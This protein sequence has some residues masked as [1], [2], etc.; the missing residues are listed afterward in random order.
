KTANQSNI[1]LEND[2]SVSL[3]KNTETKLLGDMYFKIADDDDLR[4]Y[5]KVDY[6][7]GN[8]T[9]I[10]GPT[11]T[12]TVK[13]TTNITAKATTNVTV[14][15]TTVPPTVVVTEKPETTPAPSPTTVPG[16]EMVFAIA[17]L[18]AVAYI[19]LRQRK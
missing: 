17:G 19:V 12:A 9:I 15:A 14:V 6:Q 18:L 8:E 11:G 3:S 2:G 16:F 4:F 10:G 7:V 1:V 5:P 13:G